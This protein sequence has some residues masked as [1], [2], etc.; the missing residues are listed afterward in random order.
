[1]GNSE[2]LR[3]EKTRSLAKFRF[4]NRVS[5][6]LIHLRSK[7]SPRPPPLLAATSTKEIVV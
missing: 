5:K 2:L 4:R 6:T 3:E 7:A 1:M